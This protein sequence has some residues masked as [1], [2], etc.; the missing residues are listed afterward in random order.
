MDKTE[1]SSAPELEDDSFATAES[2]R[3]DFMQLIAILDRRLANLPEADGEVRAQVLDARDAAL[4]G[5]TL[6]QELVDTL[7]SPDSGED[8]ASKR[9]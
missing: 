4:R 3:V 7:R 1:C 9:H 5:L 8:T 2:V 6:S